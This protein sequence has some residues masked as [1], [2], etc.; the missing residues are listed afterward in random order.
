MVGVVGPPSIL[1]GW[2]A[3]ASEPRS[4]VERRAPTRA[5]IR[6]AT[7]TPPPARS[8]L[9]PPA[10]CTTCSRPS[11]A[12]VVCRRSLRASCERGR[13][14]ACLPPSARSTGGPGRG[15][16]TDTQY[17]MG[18]IT[19]TFV[20]VAVM[21]LR[22]AG[23][24]DLLDRFEDHVPDSQLGGATIAQL[25]SHGAG[26]QAETNGP[27]GSAR[28]VPTGTSWRDPR[29]ASVSGPAGASTTRTSA[30]QRWGSSWPAPRRRLFDVIRR[31]LLDPLGMTRTTTRPSG[32]AAPGL[33]V[34]PFADVCCPNPST[35]PEPWPRPAS[36]GRPWT[37]SLVGRLRRRRHRRGP[38]GRHADRDVRA[39]TRSTT[40][41]TPWSPH[42]VSLA[43]LERRRNEVCRSWRLDARFPRGPARRDRVR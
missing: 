13:C 34:H 33:A 24:L 3:H 30:S 7:P 20:A 12:A 1:P 22:D 17:R 42:T 11:S 2:S 35:T 32:K 25:L 36:C 29:W 8:T 6:T 40:T 43:G 5:A 37:T 27:C 19:K 9:L 21:R 41:R 23:R 31:D 10:T 26:V 38:V 4:R 15:A 16:D 28:Q 18:S 39:R 14:L